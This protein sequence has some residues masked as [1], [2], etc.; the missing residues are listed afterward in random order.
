MFRL[1]AILS[2]LITIM[3]GWLVF[4]AIVIGA[5]IASGWQIIVASQIG[6]EHWHLEYLD[7]DRQL[8]FQMLLPQELRANL[9]LSLDG[10]IIASDNLY[11]LKLF[12]LP[13][14]N[15]TDLPVGFPQ[16]GSAD[17]GY[18]TYSTIDSKDNDERPVEVQIVSIDDD[19]VVSDPSPSDLKISMTSMGRLPKHLA[20]LAYINSC[21]ELL[22]TDVYGSNARSIVP[23]IPTI[24]AFTWSPDSQQIAFVW[25][26]SQ[27]IDR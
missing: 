17:S 22:V 20:M 11:T 19:G 24:Q 2:A 21:A 3:I 15:V 23:D 25:L 18:F 6:G 13:T 16:T 14:G 9:F 10:R 7:A 27:Y 1:F 12:H 26:A 8:N 5:S 4:L